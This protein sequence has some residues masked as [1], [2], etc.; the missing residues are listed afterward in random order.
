M[1]LPALLIILMLGVEVFRPLRD[2]RNALHSGM[3]SLS[4]SKQIFSLLD[5]KPLVDD[6]DPTSQQADM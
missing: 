2:L 6:A 1:E 3:L 5:E 4:S